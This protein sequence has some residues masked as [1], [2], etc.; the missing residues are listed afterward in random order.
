MFLSKP[1]P[2]PL[3]A[4]PFCG[5]QVTPALLK[6]LCSEPSSQPQG[7]Q[8]KSQLQMEQNQGPKSSGLRQRQLLPS[9]FLLL[10]PSRLALEEQTPSSSADLSRKCLSAHGRGQLG[11]ISSHRFSPRY[12]IISNLIPA[13]GEQPSPAICCGLP[14]EGRCQPLLPK[15]DAGVFNTQPSHREEGDH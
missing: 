14:E 6:D 12:R 5:M 4:P 10:F 13:P 7:P 9:C 15:A 11:E 8:P 3:P 1:E 2:E